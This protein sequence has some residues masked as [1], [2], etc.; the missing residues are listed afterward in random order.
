MSAFDKLEITIADRL[1]DFTDKERMPSTA[2]KQNIVKYIQ[3]LLIDLL[4]DKIK[5]IK[6]IRSRTFAETVS[7][8]TEDKIVENY[9]EN[10]NNKGSTI[11]T[12]DEL[13]NK[14]ITEFLYSNTNSITD[15][16]PLIF[17]K[18]LFKYAPQWLHSLYGGRK[19]FMMDV[20]LLTEKDICTGI[21]SSQNNLILKSIATEY[22][23]NVENKTILNCSSVY[24]PD[25]GTTLLTKTENELLGFDSI[26]YI[27]D[28]KLEWKMKDEK[29]IIHIDNL[30][31]IKMAGSKKDADDSSM[32]L[33]LFLTFIEK[34]LNTYVQDSNKKNNFKIL[35]AKIKQLYGLSFEKFGEDYDRYV[36]CLTDLKSMGDLLQVKMAQLSNSI[37]VSNDRVTCLMSSICYNNPTI[38]TRKTKPSG[39]DNP[40][41]RELLIFDESNALNMEAV[42]ETLEKANK[43]RKIQE[44]ETKQKKIEFIQL[45]KTEQFLNDSYIEALESQKEQAIIKAEQIKTAIEIAKKADLTQTRKRKRDEN[46]YYFNYDIYQYQVILILLNYSI[47]FITLMIYISKLDNESIPSFVE[48]SDNIINYNTIYF[49]EE[50]EEILK[51]RSLEDTT[52]NKKKLRAD[53]QTTFLS[54][55]I[56]QNLFRDIRYLNSIFK[57]EEITDIT[58]ERLEKD[59]VDDIPLFNYPFDD[60]IKVNKDLHIFNIPQDMK[61]ISEIQIDNNTYQVGFSKNEETIKKYNHAIL[62]LGD[63]SE[64]Y[65]QQITTTYRSTG[66]KSTTKRTA[67]LTKYSRFRTIRE[68]TKTKTNKRPDIYGSKFFNTLTDRVPFKKELT[69][70]NNLIDTVINFFINY[71]KHLDRKNTVFTKQWNTIVKSKKS[72]FTIQQTKD[73]MT[74]F[75]TLKSD[76][77]FTRLLFFQFL[78]IVDLYDIALPI[79]DIIPT[80]GRTYKKTKKL[81]YQTNPK[82]GT[83]LTTIPEELTKPEQ[84]GGSYSHKQFQFSQQFISQLVNRLTL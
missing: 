37:F 9:Y 66:G 57:E 75:N 63:M 28:K 67:R 27:N 71:L 52:E 73:F 60:I 54:T 32:S 53:L 36:L 61:Y 42:K 11:Q 59:L 72:N 77:K 70:S 40:S 10:I 19:S 23:R 16:R 33:P 58:N 30:T 39:R 83:K 35:D 45:L 7:N 8:L 81:T 41:V 3:K 14:P 55:Y 2:N 5:E 48:T 79:I 34:L 1:H 51:T 47:G 84:G 43:K 65:L 12:I 44:A 25:Q 78:F 82:T 50:V 29:G 80:K 69:F 38:R 49:D 74:Q 15:S 17:P 4:N 13:Y 68:K 26:H 62:E 18:N 21:Q 56:S 6:N 64:A 76:Y 24:S 31:S 20:T 22:D 46:I